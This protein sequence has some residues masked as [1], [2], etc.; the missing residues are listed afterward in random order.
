M[1]IRQP[2]LPIK[3]RLRAPHRLLPHSLTA[4]AMVLLATSS[5]LGQQQGPTGKSIDGFTFQLADGWELEKIATSELVKWPIAATWDPSGN[6]VIAES[7]GVKQS[8]QEQLQ[9]LPHRLVRLIDENRDGSYDKRQVVAEQLAFPEG[10]LCLGND[11]L[12]SA[13]P[14]I[15]RLIDSDGDGVCERREVWHDGKTLTGCANDLHGPFVGPEGWIYWCKAAF[16]EQSFPIAGPFPAK[17]TASHLYRRQVDAPKSDRLM[18]GG[19]D[20]L[21]DIAFDE[22]GD[23]FF[24]STFLHHPGNGLRDGIGHAVYGMSLERITRCC[25]DIREPDPL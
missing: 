17:S 12:V 4:F 8:V 14:Q 19:M 5:G 2:H 3:S 22:L 10:V 25:A 7:A 6:L 16:A 18:T 20:N 15:W 11:I 1:K 13:P 9:S 23:K 24:V 21:V